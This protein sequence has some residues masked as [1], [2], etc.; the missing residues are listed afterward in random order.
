M[1]DAIYEIKFMRRFAGLKLG[2]LTDETIILKF[3]HFLEQHGLARISH[4]PPASLAGWAGCH[5]HRSF[6]AMIA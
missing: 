1:E 2:R 5:H 6:A 3:R 4:R